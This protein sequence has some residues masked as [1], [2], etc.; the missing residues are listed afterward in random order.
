MIILL[1][2]AEYESF[3]LGV[4]VFRKAAKYLYGNT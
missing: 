1:Y 4:K 2:L 3:L